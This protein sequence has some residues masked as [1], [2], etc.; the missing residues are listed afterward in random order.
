MSPSHFRFVQLRSRA[1]SPVGLLF[2]DDCRYPGKLG[3]NQ[4]FGAG[5]YFSA[6]AIMGGAQSK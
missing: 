4:T 1:D 3:L 6:Q 5:G 2:A